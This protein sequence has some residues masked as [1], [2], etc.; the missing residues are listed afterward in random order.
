M[1]TP[2][3]S[4]DYLSYWEDRSFE[5]NCERM[6]VEKF[7]KKI[8][9][10]ET[11][12]DIGGGFGRLLSL[13]APFFHKCVIIDPS[14]KLLAIGR[15]LNKNIKNVSFKKA[16]LPKLPFGQGTFEVA[17]MIRVSHHLPHLLPALKEI[18]RVL[19]TDGFLV[20]EVANKIHFLARVRA[21][22]T[23]DFFFAKDLSSVERRS[24]ESIKHRSIAFSN[25]HPRQ[26]I[27]DLTKAGFVV[28]ET[29]SVSNF[30]SLFLKKI[31]P[32]SWLLEGEAR[33]QKPLGRLFFGP[34]IF[35]LAQKKKLSF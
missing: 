28:R 34:S 20:L 9:W 35:I 31:F 29:S 11:V 17:L 21:F 14:E 6:A 16:S 30:R 22:L 24:P 33:C 4:Y 19:K 8:G 26:V 18:S 23:G 13:Y 32:I 2:Y 10:R 27:G 3:D 15:Q 25:H 5:D 12:I 1:P 7:L